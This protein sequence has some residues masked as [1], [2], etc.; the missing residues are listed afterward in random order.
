MKI[1]RIAGLLLTAIMIVVAQAAAWAAEPPKREFR[2]AWISTVHQERYL[3][4]TTE[5]NKALIS[6][7]LDKLQAAGVNAVLFQARPSSDAF[8]A[9]KYEPWS[10]YLTNGGKAPQPYWD[11]LEYI[12]A[13]AHKRGMELHV[14]VNPYRVTAGKGHTPAPSHP[15]HKNPGR[16]I[17]YEGDGKLYFDPGQPENRKFIVDVISDIADRYD[18]DGVHFDDYFYPYPAG[19]K[20]FNDDASYKKHGNGMKRGDWRRRNVD[21]L[22]SEVHD[23]LRNSRR[24]WVRF[25]ISPFGIWRNK[26]SDPKGS[27]TNG[28]QNYDDLYA[29]VM[30]WAREGWIDYLIPQLYWELEHKKASSLELVKWWADATPER[31][32]LY[33]GQDVE[34]TMKTPGIEK[35]K[36]PDQLNHKMRLTREDS[37]ILGNCWWSGYSLIDNFQGAATRLGNSWQAKKALV[38]AY[39]QLS[40]KAPK[41]VSDIKISGNKL[42]WTGE[43]RQGKVTDQAM[44]VVYKVPSAKASHIADPANIVGLTDGTSMAIPGEGVYTVTA[45]SHSNVESRPAKFVTYKKK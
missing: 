13:E 25:G 40:D 43:K 38:P 26:A 22:I 20:P 10:R 42:T 21:L 3:K 33:I 16:F 2:G 19:G 11:P 31:C 4:N 17:T 41:E 12:I 23:A 29:D 18:I 36:E 44:Y 27:N 8:Y 5:Q 24:P 1:H 35:N 30:L 45:L 6:S 14:W 7:M 15:Y 34:R 32:Q 39:P 9:S 28:L 37:R